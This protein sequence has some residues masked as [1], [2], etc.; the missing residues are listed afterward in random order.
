MAEQNEGKVFKILMVIISA[1]VAPILV[2]KFTDK[3]PEPQ[4][5][6]Q[7]VPDRSN[8]TA[9]STSTGAPV[10]FPRSTVSPAQSSPVSSSGNGSAVQASTA[11]HC[12]PGN[13][14]TKPPAATQQV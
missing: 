5:Q 13:T 11:S 3:K 12:S 8:G 7:N 14:D 1:I 2:N 9:A 6:V 4:Q 10:Q